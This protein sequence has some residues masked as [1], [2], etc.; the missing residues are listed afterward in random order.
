MEI[1][2]VFS[3]YYDTE[4]LYSVMMNEREL[5]L[6]AAAKEADDEMSLRNKLAL[7][8]AGIGGLGA[9][10][11]GAD[12]Y[13]DHVLKATKKKLEDKDAKLT[14]KELKSLQDKLKKYQDKDMFLRVPMKEY[15]KAKKWVTNN[16]LKAGLG[17][18]GLAGLGAGYYAL[19][20]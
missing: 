12:R 15:K 6:F 5:R 20:D 3:N 8:A 16:K 19:G 13:A 1:Q 2:K 7:G 17:A 18:A 11:Y 9:A 4:R 10:V 14:K